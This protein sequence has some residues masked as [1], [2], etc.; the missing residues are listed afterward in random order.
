MTSN[1]TT[2]TKKSR[3][4]PK[5][6]FVSKKPKIK[7][8][9]PG[10]PKKIKEAVIEPV[11]TTFVN[12]SLTEEDSKKKDIF[13]LAMFIFS[14]L[15]FSASLYFSQK[16]QEIEETTA[17]IAETEQ[18][19]DTENNTWDA[20]TPETQIATG[21]LPQVIS[22]SN[23]LLSNFYEALNKGTIDEIY[24]NVHPTLKA[25]KLFKIYFSK[26]RTQRFT[27]NLDE[28]KIQISNVVS[29]NLENPTINYTLS[30]AL[31]DGKLFQEDRQMSI[32]NKDTPQIAKI[33]C[34]STGCSTGPFFNPWK[35]AIH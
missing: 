28:S 25:S 20:N 2:N 9:G 5:T 29:N 33:M 14:L 17:P 21:E 24:P 13:I 6:A 32:I 35:Y 10:R 23:M 15:I 27:N 18:I 30:Y 22:A 11:Q 7:Q 26:K 8:D 3:G 31:Q 16:K 19:I 34:I 1:S 4:R 12:H